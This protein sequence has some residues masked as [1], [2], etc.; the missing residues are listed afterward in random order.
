MQKYHQGL[1]SVY[2]TLQEK[3]SKFPLSKGDFIKRREEV[4]RQFCCE[5]GCDM[6]VSRYLADLW[7]Q[8][9]TGNVSVR[10]KA[11]NLLESGAN[12]ISIPFNFCWEA[13]YFWSWLL[14]G[15]GSQSCPLGWNLW[16]S[17]CCLLCVVAYSPT[18]QQVEKIILLHWC[19]DERGQA[20]CQHCFHIPDYWNTIHHLDTC[21]TELLDL[22]L[23]LLLSSSVLSSSM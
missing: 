19:R 1:Y 10:I 18:C 8:R 14:M 15:L 21:T 17:L 23:L 6:H 22:L 12:C 20:L 7:G 3:Y 11:L 2:L 13:L 4:W 16:L 9:K 5:K